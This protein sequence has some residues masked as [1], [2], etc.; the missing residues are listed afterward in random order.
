VTL[1]SAGNGTLMTVDVRMPDG[2]SDMRA[3]EW[4]ATPHMQEGWSDTIDRLVAHYTA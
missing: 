3:L 4:M 1:E 2:M